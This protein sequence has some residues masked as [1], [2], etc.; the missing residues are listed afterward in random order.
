AWSKLRRIHKH[1]DH[2]DVAHSSRFAH[3]TQVSFVQRAHRGNEADGFVLFTADFARD[4][5]HALTAVDDLHSFEV[6]I[7]TSRLLS[8]SRGSRCST[9]L[10]SRRVDH[11]TPLAKDTC[12]CER[13]RHIY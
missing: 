7:R 8:F 1:G 2:Y 5:S 9:L 11:T 6:G 12:H 13:P 10:R 4:G 3:E